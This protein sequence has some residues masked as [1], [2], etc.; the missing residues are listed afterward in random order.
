MP[1]GGYTKGLAA[2]RRTDRGDGDISPERRGFDFFAYKPAHLA[3]PPTRDALAR[4]TNRVQQILSDGFYLGAVWTEGSP[5]IEETIYWLNLLIDTTAPICGNAAQRMH[6]MIS[7][8]GPKNIVDS[9]D[10]IASRVWADEQGRN[11]AGAVLIQEQRVFAARA[12][13]K[14]DARPGGYVA[15]G[16]HG[17]I[18]GAAGHDG[19]PLLHYL[20]TARHTWRSAV[21]LTSLP[22]Q[23]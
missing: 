7:N 20:P 23:V 11:Q 5:N 1:P 14:G 6:G 16:G 21:N 10:Y 13:Q 19:P 12:V 9:V 18:L 17:G 4:A 22:S 2:G 15:T 3:A 8:D